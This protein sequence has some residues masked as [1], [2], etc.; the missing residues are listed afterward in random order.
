MPLIKQFDKGSVL[1]KEW[2]S[3]FGDEHRIKMIL[4]DTM[5]SNKTEGIEGEE[6][7]I[8]IGIIGAGAIAQRGHIP[9]FLSINGVHIEAIADCDRNKAK[10]VAEKAGITRVFGDY[11]EMLS[12]EDLDAVSVCVP[13]YLHAPITIAACD[14]GKHVL[15]EKPIAT[16]LSDAQ[17]MIDAAAKNRV[18]LMIEQ[19]KRFTPPVEVAKS[20]LQLGI[21]GDILAVRSKFGH[22]GA[23]TWSPMGHWFFEKAKSGGGALI[24]LGIHH[25]DLINWYTEGMQAET[26]V[27]M[28]SSAVN[29]QWEV[30]DYA[31][32]TLR[33]SSGA[34]ANLEVSWC[35]TPPFDGTEIVGTKGTLFVNYPEMP[36]VVFYAFGDVN[37]RVVPQIPR[38]SKYGSPFKHF[39]SCIREGKTPLTPGEV[40][41]DALRIVTAIRESADQG[42]AIRLIE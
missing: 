23:H 32:G 21:V 42:S 37:E 16:T 10:M 5:I 30:E 7:P 36:P 9:E 17:R 14:A 39:I 34:M 11:Q 31:V 33:Y 13:N 12:S 18:I 4:D 22:W 24:D 1:A 28:T 6:R 19:A 3:Q 8:N 25:A 15:C 27:G 41:R 40:G 20:L 2:L 29:K 38:E 26:V 35:T